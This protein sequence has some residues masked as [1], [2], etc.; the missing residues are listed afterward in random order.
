MVKPTSPAEVADPDPADD[1]IYVV[2]PGRKLWA[3]RAAFHLPEM[4]YDRKG[5]SVF[6]RT[7]HP[8]TWISSNC[9]VRDYLAQI[10]RRVD[11]VRLHDIKGEAEGDC[12]PVEYSLIIDVK[13]TLKLIPTPL[14]RLCRFTANFIDDRDR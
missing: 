4:I 5:T 6:P 1:R 7:I 11:I 12:G 10:K 14:D 9:P 3:I 8:G 2:L 13:I